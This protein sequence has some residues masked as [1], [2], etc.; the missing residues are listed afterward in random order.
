MSQY[1]VQNEN[2]KLSFHGIHCYNFK[3]SPWMGVQDI[4]K[5]IRNG[6]L[7]HPC[8]RTLNWTQ[9]LT[10]LLHGIEEMENQ[11]IIATTRWL[12]CKMQA[13]SDLHWGESS[14]ESDYGVNWYKNWDTW[15]GKTEQFILL[16]IYDVPCARTGKMWI[17]FEH[18]RPMSLKRQ[19]AGVI[20]RKLIQHNIETC[21]DYIPNQESLCL[22]PYFVLSAFEIPQICKTFIQEEYQLLSCMMTV[23]GIII[24]GPMN[25]RNGRRWDTL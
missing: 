24:Y 3:C 18:I 22:T 19:A 14:M 1:S 7:C 9:I 6:K 4:N 10:E 23:K 20:A 12:N 16:D 25:P 15:N 11:G 13:Y 8:F 21:C 5:W 2:Y 17:K